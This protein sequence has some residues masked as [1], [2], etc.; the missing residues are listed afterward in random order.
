ME[1]NF[2]STDV[3]LIVHMMKGVVANGSEKTAKVK[4]RK[5][6]PIEQG[7]K[8]GTTNDFKSAWYAGIT[9]E[10]VTTLYIG[11]DDNSPMPAGSTGG[12]LAAPLWRKYYQKMIDKDVYK[13][14]KFKFMED[15]IR[16]GELVLVD[17]DSRT[18]FAGEP[19]I[20]SRRTGLFKRGNEPKEEDRGH[21]LRLKKFF[22][23]DTEILDEEI[24]DAD[25]ELLAEDIED[26]DIEILDEEILEEENKK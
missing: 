11:Y 23:E 7:G 24:E 1:K 13:P 18:G 4:D 26:A 21:L 8:T 2:K 17:I 25:A 15:H 10:H 3:S 20:G 19:T 6:N 16:K 22:R 12:S 5:G 14:G 9:P